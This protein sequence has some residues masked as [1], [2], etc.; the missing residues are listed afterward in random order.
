MNEL[1]PDGAR[2]FSGRERRQRAPDLLIQQC[3]FFWQPRRAN[4]AA[5][6]IGER[7]YAR[8]DN[9]RPWSSRHLSDSPTPDEGVMDG[10]VYRGAER[11]VKGLFSGGRG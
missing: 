10:S 2:L 1:A 5:R 7:P 9:N 11:C 8:D 3:K 4:N 6:T